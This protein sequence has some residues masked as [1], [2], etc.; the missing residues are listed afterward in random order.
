MHTEGFTGPGRSAP[1]M[2]TP[3]IASA[4]A[5]MGSPPV[6]RLSAREARPAPRRDATAL[7]RIEELA[8][9]LRIYRIGG[10]P[11][12]ESLVSE[13][14]PVL[15]F[16]SCWAYGLRVEDTPKLSFFYGSGMPVEDMRGHFE[17][18]I[19]GYPRGWGGYDPRC[20]AP[21]QRNVPLTLREAT[22]LAGKDLDRLPFCRELL[23]RVGIAGSDQLRALVCEGDVLLAWV[24]GFRREPFTAREKVLLGRMVPALRQRLAFERDVAD[25]PLARAF[26]SAAL[27][28]FSRP[29]FVTTCSGQVAYANAVGRALLESDATGT[30]RE[31]QEAPSGRGPYSVTPVVAPGLPRHF[32]V[33]R[34]PEPADPAPRLLL[35]ARAWG[36]TPRDAEVLRLLA[37]GKA[38][39]TIA[40][41]LGCAES[42]VEIHVTRLFQRTGCTCRAELAARFWQR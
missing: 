17:G 34:W 13:L 39:K 9:S 30:R 41:E 35:L 27:E 19:R 23:P 8:A 15:G 40:A 31:L 38:N 3:R 5:A 20:P 12:L 4:A 42:T 16:E 2:G 21:S 33:V 22:A 6:Q 18:F 26:V 14:R 36:L 25:A 10:R 37:L 32:V 29:A 24:G 7:R 28:A 1:A 11:A